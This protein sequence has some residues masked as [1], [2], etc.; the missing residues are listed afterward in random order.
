MTIV[1]P[2]LILTLL[3]AAS[4]LSGYSIPADPPPQV[5]EMTTAEMTERACKNKHNVDTTC[6]NV[7][8]LYQDGGDKLWVDGEWAQSNDSGKSE[9]SYIVH[10]L[11]H[12][13]Q[14]EHGFGGGGCPRLAA[15]EREAYRTQRQ[16]IEQYEHKETTLTM[17]ETCGYEGD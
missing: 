6:G 16:Y 15:R 5:I 10:E 7:A 2:A 8:A 13:L 3:Q 12:W 9:N 1:D 17:P 14:Y 11:T 4:A